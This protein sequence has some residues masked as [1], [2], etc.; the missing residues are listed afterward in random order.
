MSTVERRVMTRGEFQTSAEKLRP[1][2]GEC[3]TQPNPA[4]RRR[5]GIA[6]APEGFE[7]VPGI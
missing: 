7:N 5:I 1:V 3:Q 6:A 4:S 2:S